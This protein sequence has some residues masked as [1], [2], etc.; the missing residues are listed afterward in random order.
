[1]DVMLTTAVS[2]HLA[3][4]SRQAP[5]SR[6]QAYGP[7][8]GSLGFGRSAAAPVA[9]GFDG[10]SESGLSRQALAPGFSLSAARTLPT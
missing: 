6:L 7:R 10:R 4:G 3:S 8:I 1:M 2:F 9:A 5:G